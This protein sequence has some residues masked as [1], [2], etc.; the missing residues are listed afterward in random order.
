MVSLKVAAIGSA[1]G[2]FDVGL[3]E[4]EKRHVTVRCK[5]A[6]RLLIKE[7]VVGIVNEYWR[8][9]FLACGDHTRMTAK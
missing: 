3:I 7:F 1:K 5:K 9:S 4:T 2:I 8:S 6:L